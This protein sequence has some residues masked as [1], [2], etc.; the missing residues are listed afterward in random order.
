MQV[1]GY[2]NAQRQ[3]AFRGPV[4][5][6]LDLRTTDKVPA[7]IHTIAKNILDL[8]GPPMP[9]VR[10]RRRGL[11]YFDDSQIQG[12][13]VRC[14]HGAD[15]P[16]ISIELC[17]IADFRED[18][19]LGLYAAERVLDTTSNEEEQL[20]GFALDWAPGSEDRA[21]MIRGIGEEN[22]SALED[23]AHQEK[24]RQFLAVPRMDVHDLA[25]LYRASDPE[26]RF[27]S[28]LLE[29]LAA[30]W[31]S[32]LRQNPFRIL[33]RE[34][35]TSSG[36]RN[37]FKQDVSKALLGFRDHFRHLITPLR[38]PVALE[39]IVKPPR[40]ASKSVLHDLDNVVRNYLIPGVTSALE[41]PSH[42]AHALPD[43][44]RRDADGPWAETL[45][46]LPKSAAIGMVRYEV[47]RIPRS[48]GDE[49][50]GF[51]S[52]AVVADE[53]GWKDS[54]TRLDAVIDRWADSVG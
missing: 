30:S 48:V 29:E 38:V 47:W 18:L 9:I 45:R 10:T 33:L 20:V 25:Y 50:P 35:P 44:R 42:V 14:E 53:F 3:R 32:L 43:R 49:A 41:P 54:L 15:A 40:A 17:S 5:L 4:V 21:A 6:S 39:V 16:L 37:A 34:L 7:H 31:E 52:A 24:Q 19:A 2:L 28:K 51:V 8:L 26:L 12:L 22:Y 27:N 36:L 46:R 23:I 11:L 13:V 1:L